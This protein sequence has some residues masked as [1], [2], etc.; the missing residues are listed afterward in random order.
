MNR[1]APMRAPPPMPASEQVSVCWDELESRLT[2]LGLYPFADDQARRAAAELAD[3]IERSGFECNAEGLELGL[4]R[5]DDVLDGE[6]VGQ[7]MKRYRAERD[8]LRELLARTAHRN[9]GPQ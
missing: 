8:E 2:E 3:A 6:S 5:G 7:T 4:A 9:G 1:R